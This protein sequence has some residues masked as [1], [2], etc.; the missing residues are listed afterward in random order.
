M[1]KHKVI[2]R[3]GVTRYYIKSKN[4][5]QLDETA[6]QK[7]RA[8]EVPGLLPVEAG[9]KKNMAQLVYDVT[10][11]VNLSAFLQQ[12]VTKSAFI[13]LVRNI[14]NIFTVVP[15]QHLE[16]FKIIFENNSIFVNPASV[17]LFFIY[18][19]LG[20]YESVVTLRDVL[21]NLA[22]HCH[23][24]PAEDAGYVSQFMTLL[25]EKASISKLELS[26]LLDR[27]EGKMYHYQESAKKKCSHCGALVGADS[28]FCTNCGKPMEAV[29]HQD[30]NIYDPFSDTAG[31]SGGWG[32]T[33]T[34]ISDWMAPDNFAREPER[35]SVGGNAANGTTVLGAVPSMAAG[36]EA[37][38]V[39][40]NQ[41]FPYLI[42]RRTGE[43]VVIDRSPFRVGKERNQCD[44]CVPDN[45]AV[46]RNHADIFRENG[47]CYIQDNSSTNGTYINGRRIASYQKM[48]LENEVQLRLANEDFLFYT[49]EGER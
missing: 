10:G 40:A 26:A 24:S 29:S 25:N 12:P 5:S 30:N 6:V 22:M 28:V 4:V 13:S 7:L 35:R 27:M 39:L 37:T 19:P 32:M 15:D 18:V 1:I 3:Y 44:Y 8:R 14:V 36:S 46:S 45:S 23:Y 38:T 42:R 9:T 33:G 21:R 11:L 34:G 47:A 48:K 49:E 2:S 31:Q 16:L 20:D 41:N 43:K 17:E